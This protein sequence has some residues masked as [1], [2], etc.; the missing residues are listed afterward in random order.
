MGRSFLGNVLLRSKE[1]RFLQQR[2]ELIG[3]NWSIEQI[4]HEML[5]AM[6][7]QQSPLLQGFHAGANN[8]YLLSGGLRNGGLY[9][10]FAGVVGPQAL[11]Q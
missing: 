9:G 10:S 6:L 2:F 1:R 11:N 4:A 3:G 8:G 7:C 5:A